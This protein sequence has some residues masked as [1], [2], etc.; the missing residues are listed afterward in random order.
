MALLKDGKEPSLRPLRSSLPGIYLDRVGLP[1][2]TI[3]D[4]P[5]L[6]GRGVSVAP[7]CSL[8]GTIV[9]KQVRIGKGCTLRSTVVW[10]GARIG[11]GARL[12][13]CIITSGVYVPPE[14][15]LSNKIVLRVEGYQGK[16]ERF[17]RL[18]SSWMTGF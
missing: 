16:K 5:V 11:D 15:T 8:Q 3:L 14:V 10:D 1:P 4:P 12:S 7:R 17:E 6:L 13:D 18:G 2:D 9:G